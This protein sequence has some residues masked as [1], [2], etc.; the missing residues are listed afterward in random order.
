MKTLAILIVTTLTALTTQA[1][2]T[3][4]PNTGI[5]TLDG[6]NVLLNE[7]LDSANSKVFVFWKSSDQKCRE[8]LESLQTVWEDTLGKTNIQLISICVDCNGT[9]GHVKPYIISKAFDFETFV[10]VN[11]DLKRAMSVYS[12][13]CTIVYDKNNRLICRYDNYCVGYEAMLC[14]KLLGETIADLKK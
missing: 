5:K 13:P 6:T 4:L 8:N 2:T 12:V 7:I 3:S 1:Q 11:G 14:E 10:D 9:W